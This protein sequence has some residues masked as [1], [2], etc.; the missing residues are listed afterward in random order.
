MAIHR[1]LREGLERAP[2]LDNDHPF[3]G[4]Y[5]QEADQKASR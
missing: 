4:F 2:I 1:T 5:A 3:S